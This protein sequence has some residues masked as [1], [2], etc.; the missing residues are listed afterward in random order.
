[1]PPKSTNNIV[2]VRKTVSKKV[3]LLDG[4]IFYAKYKRATKA[5]LPANVRI[6]R[7]YRQWL[8][9]LNCRKRVEREQGLG[10]IFSFVKK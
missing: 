7:G 2:M 6:I 8:L 9:P 5:A 4:R 10:K 1:M 3:D